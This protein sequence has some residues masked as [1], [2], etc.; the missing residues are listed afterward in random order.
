M[1][2]YWYILYTNLV[3]PITNHPGNQSCGNNLASV[4]KKNKFTSPNLRCYPIL[5]QKIYH[6]DPKTIS[7]LFHNIP[8]SQGLRFTGR[9]WIQ[10]DPASKKNRPNLA[11]G[12][13]SGSVAGGSVAGSQNFRWLRVSRAARKLLTT[14]PHME[15]VLVISQNPQRPRLSTGRATRFGARWCADAPAW[16]KGSKK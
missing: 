6:Y 13:C 3:N 11:V 8:L 15:H 7:S 5:W 1:R 2:Y 14:K 9:I 4:L 10:P 12:H 16:A